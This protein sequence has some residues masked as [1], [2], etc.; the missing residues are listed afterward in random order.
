MWKGMPSIIFSQKKSFSLYFYI[1]NEEK[2]DTVGF[3]KKDL[4]V[5]FK[6]ARFY[7]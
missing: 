4:F 3:T 6:L 5:Q 7:L 1:Q 2:I